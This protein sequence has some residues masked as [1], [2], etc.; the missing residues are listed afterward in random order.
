MLCLKVTLVYVRNNASLGM[1][2]LDLA[3]F[4]IQTSNTV[5]L[6]TSIYQYVVLP[7]LHI[8]LLVLG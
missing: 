5:V 4:I 7:K 3:M 6:L 2:N 8:F 1:I